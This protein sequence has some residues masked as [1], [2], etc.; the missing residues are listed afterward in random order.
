MCSNQWP[1]AQLK[2]GSKNR[3]EGL[4]DGAHSPQQLPAPCPADHVPAWLAVA[5][6]QVRSIQQGHGAIGNQKS[7]QE[8][9][10]ESASGIGGCP[11]Q[12]EQLGR[13]GPEGPQ[14]GLVPAGMAARNGGGEWRA[15]TPG[16]VGVHGE[17]LHYIFMAIYFTNGDTETRGSDCPQSA[18]VG[19]RDPGRTRK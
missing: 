3:K 9:P 19:R 10:Q 16:L 1:D 12:A 4:S 18:R 5:R 17:S 15:L 7:S 8:A 14:G 11:G 6:Q 2:A 13:P